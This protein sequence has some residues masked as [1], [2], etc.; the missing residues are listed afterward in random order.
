[1]LAL[2]EREP[3]LAQIN[4]KVKHKSGLDFDARME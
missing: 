4:A 3:Q 2:I 1:V